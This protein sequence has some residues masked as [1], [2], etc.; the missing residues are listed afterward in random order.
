VFGLALVLS[1]H[2][3]HIEQFRSIAFDPLFTAEASL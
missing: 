3:K 2:E 1:L